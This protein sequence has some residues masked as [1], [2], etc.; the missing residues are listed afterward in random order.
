MLDEII[1][2]AT[3]LPSVPGAGGPGVP[4]TVA[5]SAGDQQIINMFCNKFGAGFCFDQ[6]CQDL[7]IDFDYNV[8]RYGQ[9]RVDGWIATCKGLKQP[10]PTA[11]AP[12]P[13]PPTSSPSP[14]PGQ[15]EADK[16]LLPTADAMLALTAPIL[17]RVTNIKDIAPKGV[18]TLSRGFAANDPIFGKLEEVVVRSAPSAIAR[19]ATG[20][21]ALLWPSQLGNS[22]LYTP[23]QLSWLMNSK[24]RMNPPSKVNQ[25]SPEPLEEVTIKASSLSNSPLTFP[26]TSPKAA[27][28]PLTYNLP[29]ST[30][31]SI[32]LGLDL[33]LGPMNLPSLGSDVSPSRQS[34]LDVLFPNLPGWV[35]PAL[36]GLAIVLN[37]LGFATN[38]INQQLEKISPKLSLAPSSRPDPCAEKQRREREKRKK[39]KREGRKVCYRGTYKESRFGLS[40]SRREEIPCQ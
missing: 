2:R 17:E 34:D 15:R 1:S 26:T 36:Q 38:L 20:L 4:G 5:R 6:G 29:L 32:T 39:R 33:G 14:S 10:T 19:I 37:P 18:E 31:S 3:P 30:S 27:S 12:A 22:D 35:D 8:R 24:P 16:K 21:G 25:N 7:V 9:A 28:L 23:G 11:P 40:K 13:A